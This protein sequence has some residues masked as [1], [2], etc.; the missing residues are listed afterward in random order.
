[1]PIEAIIAL[2]ALGLGIL[3]G[4]IKWA[5]WLSNKLTAMATSIPDAL[6]AIIARIEVRLD[7]LTLELERHL[8]KHNNHNGPIP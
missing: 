6:P 5:W 2:A 8:D 1:M 3:A 4:A 7:T